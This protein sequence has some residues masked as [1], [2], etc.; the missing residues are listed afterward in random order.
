M[1][2]VALQHRQDA[3]PEVSLPGKG[4]RRYEFNGQPL[5]NSGDHQPC[6]LHQ[7]RVPEIACHRDAAASSQWDSISIMV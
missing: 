5:V 3:T 6:L 1:R 7:N 4:A 2:L